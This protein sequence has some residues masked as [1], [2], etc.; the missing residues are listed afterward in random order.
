MSHPLQRAAVTLLMALGLTGCPDPQASP[1]DAGT[2]EFAP[3]RITDDAE[4]L[5]FT[6]LLADGSFQTV[7]RVANVPE[8]AR[9]QVVVVD[10]GLSPEKRRSGQVLY[11]ADLTARRE[12]GTYPYSL[13]SRFKFE[14]ELLRAPGDHSKAL[15]AECAELAASP[16]D[17]VVLYSTEWCSVCKTAAAFM[18][19][20]GI[21]FQEKDVEKDPAAQ[22]EL[23]CKALKAG[24]QLQGVPVLDVAGSLMVGFDRDTLVQ[25]AARLPR[26]RT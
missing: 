3:L 14:R 26:Q 2:E 11:V 17:R 7:E 10:T 25:L 5:L 15:P 1:P 20:E 16:A 24:K 23:A 8:A 6:Y 12:D 13:V 21:P 4:S 9:G 22:Q 18:R 19:R